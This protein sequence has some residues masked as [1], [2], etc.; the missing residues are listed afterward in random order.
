MERYTPTSSFGGPKTLFR[1]N[2]GGSIPIIPRSPMRIDASFSDEP[3]PPTTNELDAKEKARLLKKA[4]KL[5]RVFGEVPDL[6]PTSSNNSRV[7]NKTPRHH[8]SISTHGSDSELQLKQHTG[9]KFS[10]QSDLA[11]SSESGNR[12][13]VSDREAIPPVPSLP[14]ESID[15]FPEHIPTQHRQQPPLHVWTRPKPFSDDV[16]ALIPIFS[17]TPQMSD[18]LQTRRLIKPRRDLGEDKAKTTAPHALKARKSYDASLAR[19]ASRSD[20]AVSNGPLH[21]S[22][23]LSANRKKKLGEV[24]SIV[25]F[26]PQVSQKSG[27][28][29]R[30]QVPEGVESAVGVLTPPPAPPDTVEIQQLD[31]TQVYSAETGGTSILSAATSLR[32]CDMQ[33]NFDVDHSTSPSSTSIHSV[34]STFPD[35]NI[36]ENFRERRRRA[37]KLTQF[38]GVEY[39]DI[40]ASMP[41]T[42]HALEPI[43]D[44]APSEKWEPVRVEPS[45]QVG[46]RTNTRRFWGGRGNLKEAEVG[47]VI[48][49]LRELRAS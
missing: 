42:G 19:A 14:R 41:A 15:A 26:Y 29:N 44:I 20:E 10:S 34:E 28:M 6:L 2:S 33:S 22:R 25:D 16:R 4:R 5:S 49:K 38:F 3:I 39:Q 46:V 43:H 35:S 30:K 24:D 7:P 8:R 1:V 13:E 37:A 17:S 12:I 23:S 9:R 40:T 18:E 32:D 21:R 11:S 27:S 48:P 36:D 31:S 45:V 47:D